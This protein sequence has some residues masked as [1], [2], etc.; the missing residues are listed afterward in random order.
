MLVARKG[1]L[2]KKTTADCTG[3]NLIKFAAIDLG[4]PTILLEMGICL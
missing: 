1:K 4:N 3:S 2:S